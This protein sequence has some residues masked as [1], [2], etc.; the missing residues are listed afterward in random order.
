MVSAA[1]NT[2]D[3]QLLAQELSSL[4]KIMAAWPKLPGEF[5][6]AVLTVMPSAESEAAEFIGKQ[7][8]PREN[9]G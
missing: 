2:A 6:A 5:H 8:N 9:K 7:A 1:A 4:T 3:A